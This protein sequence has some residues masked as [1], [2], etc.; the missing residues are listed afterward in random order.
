H[1]EEAGIHSGDSACVLPP[2]S[3]SKEMLEE[4]KTATKV[5]AA[6]LK[7]K[8]L[9]NIQYAIKDDVLYILE[10]NPRASRTVPF[11]SKA[12]GVPLAKLATKVMMG[13]K[14]IDLGLTKEVLVNHF[15]VKEAV[16]PFD[17]FENVDTLLGPEMKS[18]GEVMGIDACLGLAFAKSQ[19][20]AGQ[21]IP[22][23]GTV[24]ISLRRGDKSAILPAAK[25]LKEMDFDIVATSGTAQFLKEHKVECEKV[26]KIS[27]GRPHILDKI[28][29][30]QIQWIINTSMG[31]RTTED[32]YSIRRSALDYHLPYTTTIAGVE[33]MVDAIST[34]SEKSIEVQS[35]QEYFK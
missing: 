14:L 28:Q 21:K 7:V 2:H 3:L 15:A 11:V 1:I 18:T 20:A 30:G 27:E 31:T 16:F 34:A 6:E 12:T 19:M 4:I 25:K 23:G 5:M 22:T 26:F 9:M 29:D 13:E 24:F 17:R 10:V 8:G 32:S 35:I 33:S